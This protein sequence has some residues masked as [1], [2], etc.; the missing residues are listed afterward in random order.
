MTEHIIFLFY[1]SLFVFS[2]IGYGEVFSRVF[3]KELL[4]YN[5]GFK[6]L[7]GFFSLSLVSLISSYFFAH[8]F[9]HNIILH[10][11]GIIGFILFFV[12]DRKNKKETIYFT[13]LLLILLIGSYV[14]KNHDDFPYYHLTYSLN[15]SE[16]KFIIGTGAFGHGFR[17]FSSIFYYHS[18]LYMPHIEFYL[19]HIGTF[20]IL[21]FFNY[22]ILDNLFKNLKEN[23]IN[24]L[25][26]FKIL[27]FIFVNIAFYRISEHGTD[28]S[29][30]ILL[31]L[32]FLFFFDL[33]FFEK[34]KKNIS[35]KINLFLILIFMASS[36][37][38]IYY[39]YL[40]LV[41]IIFINKN[42]L[43]KF[44]KKKNILLILILS[45]SISGNLITNY[46]NTGCFLYPA[47][48]TCVGE[49]SWSIPKEEVKKMK[50][51]YEWW[52]KA[53]GGPNYKSEIKPEIYVK[54]FKWVKNWIDRH[55]FNK[56][57]DTLFGIIFICLLLY[58]VFRAFSKKKMKSKLNY[59]KLFITIIIPIIFLIEWFINHPSMR[60]GGY[61][62]VGLPFFIITSFI[63]EKLDIEKKKIMTGTIIFVFISLT[64]FFARNLVRLNKEV[65]FYKYNINKSP[66][67]Y[68]EN[69]VSETIFDDG[70]FKVYS[71]A[72]NKM[73]WASK[74]PCS[75]FK[76]IK[77]EKFFGLHVVYRD[78]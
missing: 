40:V 36:M 17:T 35:T 47:V 66:F 9:I 78:K 37:K 4:N 52:S 2:T 44:L 21:V 64:L 18:I 74:T 49:N 41:P 10:T 12:R 32:I 53:G 46:F 61:V 59:L 26:Y 69:V 62:L 60:Y 22:I 50:I 14:Y 19:F 73:C 13:V 16:N 28:R 20:F 76:K 34:N 48:K 6:G 65:N 30:Q 24:F 57:T 39:M 63:L 68:V 54:K 67:F 55:F 42:F 43:F 11:V 72:N 75:N 3:N 1:I 25:H 77:T 5:I 7:I 31:L 15:L 29:A 8:N 58:L 51:H 56:V 45:L 23:K 71:T 70:N 27:S 33:I 38:A